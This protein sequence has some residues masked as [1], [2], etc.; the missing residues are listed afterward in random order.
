[1]A[2]ELLN[3]ERLMW[4]Y[5]M[6]TVQL[7]ILDSEYA[8]SLRS[9]LMRD[10]SHR[11]YVVADPD[12][13]LDGLVVIDQESFLRLELSNPSPERFIV[14]TPTGSNHLDILW[15]SGVRHVVFK[16][17]PLNTVQLAI[18]AVEMRLRPFPLSP[19]RCRAG[20]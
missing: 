17:E 19:V 1:L 18:A 4:A 16:D 7:A 14:I 15:A 20:G 3:P 10:G 8:L 13:R 9:Q 5:D 11:V 6:K 12:L 2:L